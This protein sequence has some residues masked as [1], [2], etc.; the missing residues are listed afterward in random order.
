M[1]VKQYTTE[2]IMPQNPE[3]SAQWRSALG[4]DWEAV[5]ETWLHTLGNLTLTG[6]NPEYGDRPF[7]EKRDMP[8]G[9]QGK[10]PCG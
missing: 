8:G 9:F 2:H 7:S 3:L 6:Y 10:S 4:P 5:H 1:S